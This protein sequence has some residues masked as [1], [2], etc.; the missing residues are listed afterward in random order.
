M[1][2]AVVLSFVCVTLYGSLTGQCTPK[3]KKPAGETPKNGAEDPNG[4]EPKDPNDPANP[5]PN[6]G[7]PSDPKDP[8]DPKDP[9]DPDGDPPAPKDPHADHPHKDIAPSTAELESPEL[10]VGFTSLGGAIEWLSLKKHNESADGPV[11]DLIVPADRDFPVGAIDELGTTPD[12]APGDAFRKD[13]R[14]GEMRRLHWKRNTAAEEATEANDVVFEFTTKAGVTYRKRWSLRQEDGRYDVNLELSAAGGAEKFARV[15]LLAAAGQLVEPRKGMDMFGA[16]QAVVLTTGMDEAE[17][18]TEWAHGHPLIELQSEG[19][20]TRG[21]RLLGSRSLYFTTAIYGSG[22]D[23]EPTPRW[24]W[25][26]GEQASKRGKMEEALKKWYAGRGRKI[27]GA[28]GKVNEL[29][30]RIVRSVANMQYAWAT[31]DLPTAADAEPIALSWYMGP[32]SRETLS[33]EG[34]EPLERMITYPYA[35]DIIAKGL[36]AIYDL[37]RGLFGSIGLAVIL[38]TLAVRGL[39]M[40]LSIRNQLSMRSYGRKIKKIKPKLTALQEK[41]R[42]NPRKLR[43]EQMKLYRENNIGFPGGCLMMIIQIPIWFAL[44]ASLRREFTIRGAEFLWI[45]DLSGPDA[46]I[47]F[48]GCFPLLIITFCGINILPILMVTLSL[49]HAK[50]MPKPQDDQTAQQYKMMKWMPII[51]AVILYNYTAALM[52]YMT[53]SSAF[54]IVESKIVRRKDEAAEAATA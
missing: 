41:Y 33:Q 29:G 28:D 46:L 35:P 11:L 21:L 40:P 18:N 42:K 30:T 32:I 12:A 53:L 19:V 5:D 15:R 50:S 45:G 26:T 38:M 25:A 39:M 51:F 9:K 52:L 49:W 1:L 10:K 23:E 3:P 4:D 34:Y 48:G 47:D 16:K 2:M 54:G 36:L 6:P 14:P 44:F 24:V 13:V 8:N 27:R 17:D 7:D 31:Y 20:S 43:E 22:A 37:F